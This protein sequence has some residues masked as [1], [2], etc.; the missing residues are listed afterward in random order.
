MDSRQ[1]A[2]AICGATVTYIWYKRHRTFSIRDVPGP[3][4][5]SWIYG[6]CHILTNRFHFLTGFKTGHAW[7]WESEEVAVV[8]KKILEEHG[9]IARW[10][11]S[12]GVCF[13]Y[14]GQA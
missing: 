1:A 6:T 8:E 10:N 11:G 2:L 7:W 9:T 13:F 12:L 4:N 3:K 5:P 14:G